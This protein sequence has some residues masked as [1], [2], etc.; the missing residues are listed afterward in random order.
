MYEIVIGGWGNTKTVIR[1]QS[2][3][4]ELCSANKGIAL[5]DTRSTFAVALDETNGKIVVSQNNNVILECKDPKFPKKLKYYDFSTWNKPIRYWLSDPNTQGLPPVTQCIQVNYGAQFGK[6][7]TWRPNWNIAEKG[8]RTIKFDAQANNDIH[9]SFSNSLGTT[10]P[11]YEIVIGG[12]GNTKSVVR[13]QSQGSELCSVNRGLHSPNTRSSFTFT[14]DDI[15][16]RIIVTE[17]DNVILNCLDPNFIQNL[18]YYDF[19]TWN[20]PISYWFCY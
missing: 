6:Y 10:V 15:Q 2:Q 17:N 1:K 3:G 19:S 18:K 13:R 9:V 5:P 14:L 4:P 12:W 7:L 8:V 16:G 11:M 20:T